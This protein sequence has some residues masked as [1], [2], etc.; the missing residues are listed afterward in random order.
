[1]FSVWPVQFFSWACY[2]DLGLEDVTYDN[3]YSWPLSQLRGN[4]GP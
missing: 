3:V 2:M 1:M 4:G